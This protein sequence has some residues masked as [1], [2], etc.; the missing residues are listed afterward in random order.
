MDRNLVMK[1]KTRLENE[2]DLVLAKLQSKGTEKIREASLKHPD[3][4]DIAAQEVETG[5]SLRM[6]NRE[7]LYLKKINKAISRLSEGA[8]GEC[9]ACGSEISERR[10]EARPTAELCIICKEEM[11]QNENSSVNGRKHK[12]VG[13]A[14]QLGENRSS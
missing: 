14:I 4:A 8:F 2:R 9:Q 5:M 6:G 7:S 11:E 1:F 10:L 12:S 3:E 13:L